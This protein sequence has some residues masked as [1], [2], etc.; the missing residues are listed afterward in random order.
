[1]L[2]FRDRNESYQQI[3]C[4]IIGRSG[5]GLLNEY[6]IDK[7]SKEGL[8]KGMVVVTPEGLVGQVTS[9]SEHYSLVQTII[10]ENIAVAAMV[11]NTKENNGI[12][13]GYR[14]YN[15]KSIAKIYQLP[16]NST[17]KKDDV[18]L[19]SGEG[20]LYPRGIRVGYVLEVQ[21][22]SVNIMKTALIQPYVD[23]NKL[24]EVFIIIPKDKFKIDYQ[25]EDFK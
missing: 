3:P 20:N 21:E 11:E 15:K 16:L 25:G 4:H 5:G 19:T 8:G 23:F 14:E 18:I 9:V 22:D 10:S 12:V 17:V 1:M 24:E 2:N 6:A 7:G 13:K